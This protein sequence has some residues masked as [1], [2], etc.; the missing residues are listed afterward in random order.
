MKSSPAISTKEI[1]KELN[2]TSRSVEKHIKNFRDKA[3]FIVSVS[4]KVVIGKC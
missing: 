2:M 3:S 1:A 4:T